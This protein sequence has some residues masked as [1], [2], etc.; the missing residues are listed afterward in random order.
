MHSVHGAY[1]DINILSAPNSGSI[2]TLQLLLGAQTSELLV[3]RYRAKRSCFV[4]LQ[5]S[6]S[7]QGYSIT[8]I[9]VC[10]RPLQTRE[11]G[12]LS[13]ITHHRSKERRMHVDPLSCV[14]C[15]DNQRFL[16]ST[17]KVA[18]LDALGKVKI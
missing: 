6:N 16:I 8:T 11:T 7:S 18:C 9:P 13:P 3:G 14:H 15:M 12:K 1:S 2:K 5:S 10:G 17:K 4:S